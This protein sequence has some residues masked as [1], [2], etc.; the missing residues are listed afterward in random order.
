MAKNIYPIT[1]LPCK[2]CLQPILMEW[3][4]GEPGSYWEPGSPPE[5][6]SDHGCD[7]ANSTVWDELV[8]DAYD[9][10]EY[11]AYELAE[12]KADEGYYIEWSKEFVAPLHA[13]M[14]CD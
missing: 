11:R 8:S 13:E 2:Q 3:D 7:T 4:P 6:Y 9:S 14:S 5:W 10:P 12:A 1:Y